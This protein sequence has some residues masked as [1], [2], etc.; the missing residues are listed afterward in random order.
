MTQEEKDLLLKDLCARLPYCI[1][2]KILENNETKILGSVQYDGVNTLFDFW[3]DEH[4]IQ[5]DYQLYL[6]EFKPY[7]FPLSS[8]TEEQAK[9]LFEIVGLEC[10]LSKVDYFPNNEVSSITFFLQNGFDVE[11]HLD[12]LL[13]LLNRNHFDW[14]GLIPMGLAIDCTNLNIY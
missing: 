8:M 12:K 2:C 5:Y 13:E 14:R 7:L 1:K 6:S 11:T 4:K 3:E 10:S 9:E